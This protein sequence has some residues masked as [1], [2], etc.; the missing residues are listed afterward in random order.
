M[1][2]CDSLC[3]SVCLSVIH[4]RAGKKPSSFWCPTPSLTFLRSQYYSKCSLLLERTTFFFLVYTTV[5][6]SHL[7]PYMAFMSTSFS[8]IHT[9]TQTRIHSITVVSPPGVMHCFCPVDAKRDNCQ[10]LMSTAQLGSHQ[11]SQ[12]KEEGDEGDYTVN[13]G[14]RNE[15]TQTQP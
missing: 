2:S 14:S 7:C 15:H 10:G 12:L 6:L 11:D 5:I 4:T 8:T 1:M 9:H 3:L 13:C